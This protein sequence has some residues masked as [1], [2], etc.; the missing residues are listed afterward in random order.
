MPLY[1]CTDPAC[2]L[3]SMDRLK[4]E[5]GADPLPEPQP[6]LPADEEPAPTADDAALA[7][8]L[9]PTTDASSDQ[10]DELL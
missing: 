2:K 3:T 5:T 1:L 10:E 4:A 7:D 6:L 9:A 8:E